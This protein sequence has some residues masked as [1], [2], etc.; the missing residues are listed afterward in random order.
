MNLPVVDDVP[1]DVWM[2]LGYNDLMIV[3]CTQTVGPQIRFVDCYFNRGYKLAHY[4]EW[5]KAT[6]YRLGKVVLPHDA[7]VHDLATGVTRKQTLFDL[8][9]YNIQVSPKLPIQ[10][11]IERVRGLFSRFYFDETRTK[12]LYEALGNYRKD[13]DS[14]MGEYKNTPRH[15]TNS[16]FADAVRVGAVLWHEEPMFSNEY[17][18][19]RY[20]KD[21][22][23]S[24]FGA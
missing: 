2:D 15:D 8:G 1:V 19:E 20:S 24:F 4:V 23:Q 17:D 22:D 12:P 14:K 16:H 18:R 11:G 13:F 10:D 6:G 21:T 3:I 5:L 9:L 7:E